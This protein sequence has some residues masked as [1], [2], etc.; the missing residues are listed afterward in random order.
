MPGALELV[1][2]GLGVIYFGELEARSARGELDLAG[3]VCVAL[4]G[5]GELRAEALAVRQLPDDPL[6]AAVEVAVALPELSLRAERLTASARAVELQG[7][8]FVGEVSGSA[9]TALLEP[10]TMRLTL[11]E[12]QASG[13]GLQLRAARAMLEGATLTLMTAELT[14]CDC[15]T[16]RQPYL[17]R[18]EQIV[19]DLA[20]ARAQLRGGVLVVGGLELALGDIELSASALAEL[21][22]PL[23]VEDAAD[24][25]G[26][27]VRTPQL[28]LDAATTLEL[29]V[30][31]LDG[32]H[33]LAPI[34]LLRH[35]SPEVAVTFGRAAA[36]LQL[37]VSLRRPLIAPLALELAMVNRPWAAQDFWHEG[38]MALKLSERLDAAGHA[39]SLAAELFAA[40]SRQTIDQQPVQGARLGTSAELRYQSPPLGSGRFSAVLR[41]QLS[42]YPQH[43]QAQ[44][45]LYLEPRWHGRFGALQLE[46]DARRQWTGGASPFSVDRLA[47]RFDVGASAKWAPSL[48]PE[49]TAS[50]RFGVRYDLLQGAFGE[51]S[52]RA[53]LEW[54]RQLALRPFVAFDL[55]PYLNDALPRPSFVE[56]GLELVGER[57]EVGAALR[58]NPESQWALQK[59]E[60]SGAAPLEVGSVTLEPYVAL[61][62]APTLAARSWP[63]LSGHGLKLSWASCCG[64][65]IAGYRQHQGALSTTF[66]LR[67]GE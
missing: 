7:V 9:S 2:E 36:G 58:L 17:L 21:Q 63:R 48:S 4:E 6:I 20:A 52:G 3:G 66:A 50:L 13:D 29:G 1:L 16:P 61:D 56:G 51:L 27:T 11:G 45:G 24:G 5:G 46:L 41:G 26:L 35:R 22:M 42:Y 38:R 67:L 59:L 57:W 43:Q 28:P 25:N 14:S 15:P 12:L 44:Q 33:P 8:H 39:L 49:L 65:L 54:R 37:D 30:S 47:P 64:T 55:A 31:G 53:S 40:A 23:I 62:F 60:L 18:G 10:T 34:A 32:A 19:Y